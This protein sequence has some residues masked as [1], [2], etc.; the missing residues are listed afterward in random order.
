MVI[1]DPGNEF[2]Q[3]L[4]KAFGLPNSSFNIRIDF[5]VGSLPHGRCEFYITNEMYNKLL[6]MIDDD[7][8]CERLTRKLDG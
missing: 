7:E 8:E 4:I 6:F 5:E 2:E 1:S 3:R